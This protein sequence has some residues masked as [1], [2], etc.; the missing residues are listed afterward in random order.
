[1]TEATEFYSEKLGFRRVLFDYTGPLPGVERVTGRVET[2]AHVVMLGA[3]HVGPLGQGGIKLVQ[4]LEPAYTP[5]LPEGLAWGEVGISEICVN[6]SGHEK[7][8]RHLV[9]ELNC[10]S[11]MDRVVDP[12]PPFGITTALSY[13]AD[14]YGGKVEL[15]EWSDI[16]KGLPCEPQLEGVNHVAFGVKDM[17]RTLQFYSRFGLTNLLFEFDGYFDAMAHWYKPSPPKQHIVL[18]TSWIGAGIEPVQH[19]PP[20]ADL[21]GEWGHAGPMEFAIGVSNLDRAYEELCGE[22]V[23]FHT[24]PQSIDVGCGEWRY[25]YLSDPD[26]LYV[27]LV[28]ARY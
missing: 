5:P 17:E 28:E 15:I 22:G 20:S 4:L 18:F 16:W 9:E 7:V 13:V 19:D 11:L 14:P 1:M 21:R 27:S 8:F 26:E 6:T 23:D 24:P 2:R 3:E 10:Q 12:L 25:A